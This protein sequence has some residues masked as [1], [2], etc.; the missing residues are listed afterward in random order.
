MDQALTSA[1]KRANCHAK[2][3][4]VC[5][6]ASVKAGRTVVFHNL[7]HSK[8]LRPPSKNGR[9][10]IFGVGLKNAV[11]TLAWTWALKWFLF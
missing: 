1:M 2:P 4:A 9:R 3:T 11:R 6:T 7:R 8:S 10:I 5:T